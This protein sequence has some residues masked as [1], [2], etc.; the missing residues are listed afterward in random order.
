MNEID[1]KKVFRLTVEF[2]EYTASCAIIPSDE[3][4]IKKF[5][6]TS[7]LKLMKSIDHELTDI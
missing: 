1:G 2:G 3:D 4:V 7:F 6:K 5:A